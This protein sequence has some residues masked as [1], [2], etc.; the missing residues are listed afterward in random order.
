MCKRFLLFTLRAFAG[1]N[2]CIF[3]RDITMVKS[4]NA[5]LLILRCFVF[6]ITMSFSDLLFA[7][8]EYLLGTY[9][10]GV[11]GGG[12]QKIVT[13]APMSLWM[14]FVPPLPNPVCISWVISENDVGDTLF[15]DAESDPGFSGVVDYLINGQ[16]DYVGIHFLGGGRNITEDAMTD[17]MG[18]QQV[19]FFGYDITRIGLTVHYLTFDTPGS[20]PNGD[21]I[22]TDYSYEVSTSFYGIPEPSTLLLLCLG[23]VIVRRKRR[24]G[25]KNLRCRI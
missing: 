22:W 2:N 16:H 14:N 20:N 17:A 10:W 3:F 23:G 7:S 19:D 12:T 8:D 24:G 6:I 5:R 21:G 9:Q 4:K 18:I 11:D 1:R 25:I 15:H 13:E